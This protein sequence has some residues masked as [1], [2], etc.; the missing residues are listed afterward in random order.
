MGNDK[1]YFS[2]PNIIVQF[3]LKVVSEAIDSIN[4]NKAINWDNIHPGAIKDLARNNK[5]SKNK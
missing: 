4:K 5:S 2:N 3:S 1:F